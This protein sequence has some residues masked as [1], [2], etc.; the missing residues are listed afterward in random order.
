VIRLDDDDPDEDPD[1]SDEDLDEDGDDDEDDEDDEDEEE[2]ETWQVAAAI[3][4]ANDCLC[5]TSP[6]ELPRLAPI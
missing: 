1:E 6:N 4:D 5:L 2:E 3:S